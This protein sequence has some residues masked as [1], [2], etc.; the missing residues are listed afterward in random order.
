MREDNG[1]PELGLTLRFGFLMQRVPYA[2][3]ASASMQGTE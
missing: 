1:A 2:R 3:L